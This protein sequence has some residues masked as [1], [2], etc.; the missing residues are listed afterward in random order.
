MTTIDSFTGE[1]AWLSNF[2]YCN[3]P[4][5]SQAGMPIISTTIEHQFQAM[6]F[7]DP[8]ER[9]LVLAANSPGRAKTIGGPRGGLKSYR[10]DWDIVKDQAMI[11][12]LFLKFAQNINPDL[13]DK[14]LATGHAV[15]IEGNNHGDRY[16]GTVNGEGSN[17]LGILLMAT[18]QNLRQL[19]S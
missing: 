6:K 12:L 15:L 9:L 10:K 17:H 4:D 16:W 8:Q 11:T 18:R 13:H 19:P 2:H 14:L 1:Y 3:L 7:D 5:I